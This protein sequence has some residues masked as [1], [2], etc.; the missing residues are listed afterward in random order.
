M[1][2]EERIKQQRDQRL[3][4]MGYYDVEY[5]SKKETELPDGTPVNT[6]DIIKEYPLFDEKVGQY[7][8]IVPQEVTD[9]Q[10]SRILAIGG[11]PEGKSK[12]TL[13]T[14]LTVIGWLGF[15]LFLILGMATASEAYDDNFLVFLLYAAYGSACLLGC[16]WFAEVLKLLHRINRKL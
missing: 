2:V 13:A 4:D 11:E 5:A 15:A 6:E 10:F 9:E 16:L 12:N 8:R 7:Y 3:I 14:I 1:T